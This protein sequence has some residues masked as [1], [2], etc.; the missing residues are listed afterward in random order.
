MSP[1]GEYGPYFLETG[2]ALEQAAVCL[3][4]YAKYSSLW[5]GVITAMHSSGTR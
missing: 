3:A 4:C 5:A 1:A 2:I